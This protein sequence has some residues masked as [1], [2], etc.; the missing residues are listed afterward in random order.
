MKLSSTTPIKE[1][2]WTSTSLALCAAGANTSLNCASTLHRRSDMRRLR[3]SVQLGC[4]SFR[5]IGSGK[6]SSIKLNC[7]GA[8][9]AIPCL[10]SCPRPD[11]QRSSSHRERIRRYSEF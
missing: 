5:S 2:P 11:V 8:D 10:V 3:S 9:E 4:S 6:L 7:M 1:L